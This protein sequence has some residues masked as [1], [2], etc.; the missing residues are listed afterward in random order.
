MAPMGSPDSPRI[1]APKAPAERSEDC[2][3]KKTGRPI[4]IHPTSQGSSSNH[5]RNRSKSQG[6]SSSIKDPRWPKY[7][8]HVS[9]TIEILGVHRY[10]ALLDLVTS[11]Y[12]AEKHTQKQLRSGSR[13]I[14]MQTAANKYHARWRTPVISWWTNPSYYSYIYHKPTVHQP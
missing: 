4:L 12:L 3:E 10:T 7:H 13:G 1:D 2:F 11:P 8:H 9:T 14:A 6:S 5:H